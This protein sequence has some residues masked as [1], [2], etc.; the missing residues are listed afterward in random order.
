MQLRCKCIN[1]KKIRCYSDA[2]ASTLRKSDAT[3]MPC[4]PLIYFLGQKSDRE[5]RLLTQERRNLAFALSHLLSLALTRYHSLSLALPCSHSLSLALT[6]SHS[7][8]LALTR[9]YSLSPALTCS[10]SFSLALTRTHSLSLAL[11]RF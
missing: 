9:S 1:T 8:S 2:S 7:L 5:K 4:L 10:H 3:L 6:C 11:T